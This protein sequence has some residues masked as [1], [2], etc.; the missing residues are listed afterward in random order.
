MFLLLNLNCPTLSSSNGNNDDNDSD[1]EKS[2][3]KVIKIYWTDR[4]NKKIQRA[5]LDGTRIEDIINGL[6]DL[7]CIALDL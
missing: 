1:N 2:P 4:V 7:W 5:N 3:I 6:N